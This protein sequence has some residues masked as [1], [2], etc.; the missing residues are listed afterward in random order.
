M[1][2]AQAPT[3]RYEG[4]DIPDFGD[5]SYP[6]GV[7]EVTRRCNLRCTTCFFFQAF[8]HEEK[9]LAED[10]LIASLRALQRRHGIKFMSLVGGEP[11][12]RLRVVEAAASIF[13]VSVM[14][15]NGLLPIPDLPI[16]IG[17]SL[18]GPPEIN[19]AVRGRGVYEKVVSG[20]RRAPR[21]VFIQCV[22]TQRNA[23][24]L[25]R[26]T[27]S[28]TA[29][30][31]VNGVVF[32]IYVPQR[33]DTSGLAF[34]LAERDRLI[35]LLLHLKERHGPFVFNERRALDLAHSS[36]CRRV[37]DACDM[38]ERSLALDYRLRR[39]RPCCYGENVDCDLCA[40]PTPFSIAARAQA[41]HGIVPA[42]TLQNA[43]RGPLPEA[44]LPE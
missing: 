19:D 11:L 4:V 34:P 3:M 37:T 17:V 41:R 39:R 2:V 36:T 12:L 35:D 5:R 24:V 27:E 44:R 32:S 38:K 28:L 26:F 8:Q 23:P 15:T 29:L 16:A 33:G 13:P 21:A 31:N 7:I 9:D 22:V 40:A 18:D 25:E 30:P 6:Y 1:E 10:L 14:F 20:L 43:M 42:E